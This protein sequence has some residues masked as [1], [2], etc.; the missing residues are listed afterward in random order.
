MVYM[1][2]EKYIMQYIRE[3]DISFQRVKKDTG[4]DLLLLESNSNNLLADDFLRLCIY[5]GIAPEEISDQIL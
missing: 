4:I 3:H 1:K 2:A 5:L